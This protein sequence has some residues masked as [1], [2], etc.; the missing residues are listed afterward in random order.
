MHGLQP[1]A[2]IGQRATEQNGHCIRHVSLCGLFVKL[3]RHHPPLA[4]VTVIC[5]RR[6]R[7]RDAP[8]LV[9]AAPGGPKRRGRAPRRAGG[10]EAELGGGV[11]E[12]QWLEEGGEAED[13]ERGVCHGAAED[14]VRVLEMEGRGFHRV[15]VA[16]TI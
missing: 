8:I 5:R 4:H 6:R 11:A 2:N 12:A 14:R 10:E 1:V 9:V 3:R 7:R 16:A 13:A 15:A